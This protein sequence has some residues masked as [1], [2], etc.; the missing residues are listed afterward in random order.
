[1]RKETS[2]KLGKFLVEQ[3]FKPEH[4]THTFK[5]SDEYYIPVVQIDPELDKAIDYFCKTEKIDLK[6]FLDT[7]NTEDLW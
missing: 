1:M 5:I 2:K 7:F 4:I 3:G 6:E